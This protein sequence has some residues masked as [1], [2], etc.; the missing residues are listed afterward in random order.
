MF[1]KI[2]QDCTTCRATI[3]IE[4][5]EEITDKIVDGRRHIRTHCLICGEEINIYSR[6][7]R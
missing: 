3:Y 2:K 1:C 4:S 5:K 6:V 7:T